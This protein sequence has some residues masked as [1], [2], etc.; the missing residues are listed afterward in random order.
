MNPTHFRPFGLLKKLIPLLLASVAIGNAA[1]TTSG[2]MKRLDLTL[3][4]DRSVAKVMV[5]DGVAT[6]I[7][8]KFNHEGGW[9]RFASREGKPGLMRFKLPAPADK[10]R[11]RAIGRFAKPSVAHDKFPANFYAGKNQ[12]GPIKSDSGKAGSLGRVA[13]ADSAPE[14]SGDSPVEADIW[15]VDG[16][17]VYFF[18]QL[19]GLQ[20]LN[21]A[22]PSDPR[23]TASLRLPAEGQDLYLLPGSGPERNLVLLTRGWSNGDGEWTRINVVTVA[24]G[25]AEITSTRNVPGYLSDSRMVGNRLI[26]ATTEWNWNPDTSDGEWS[27]RT[28]LGEWLISPGNAPQ[29]DGETLIEGDNPLISAGPDWLAI[30]VHP[31]G[32][33][34]VSNVSVFAVRPQGLVKMSPQIR[35]EGSVESKFAMQWADNVLTVV[36]ERNDR[37]NGWS[38]TTILE[39]FQV[40]APGSPNKTTRDRIG[41]LELAEGESLFAT[42]FA[43]NK[44]YIVTFLQ[45]DPLF[46]VDLSDPA[47]PV[48]AGQIE[49][50]GWSSHLEPIGDLLFAIG[51]EENTVV[52]SLFDVANPAD[53]Q[54]LRRLKLGDSGTYS[55]AMWDEK[56]LKVLPQAGLAL[57]PLTR[58]GARNGTARSVV[59]LIDIDTTA[60]DIRLRGSIR[61][62]FDARRADLLG[63]AVV[64]ISQRVMVAADVTDRDVPSILSEVSLAWPV[65]RVFKVGVY[66]L[67]IEDGSSYGGGRATVRVSPANATEQ[68]LAE[69]DLGKGTVRAA[70]YR[71]GKLFILRENS[72]SWT[73]YYLVSDNEDTPS[74]TIVLDVYDASSIPD[75]AL[76]GSRT[77]NVAGGGHMA[78]DRLLWPSPNRPAVVLESG[79]FYGWFRD[80]IIQTDQA[81]TFA[82]AAA[83]MSAKSKIAVNFL[84]YWLPETPPRLVV[85]ETTDPQNPAVESPVA[86]GPKGS[87]FSGVADAAHGLIVLGNT[88]WSGNADD[89]WLARGVALQAARVIEV[90]SSGSPIVRPLIDLP[91]ELFAITELDQDGFLAFTRDTDDGD[92][93]VFGINAC[94][95]YDAFS[96]ASVDGPS[97]AA[98]TAGGRRLFIAG[99]GQVLCYRLTADGTISAESPLETG[100]NPYFLRWVDGTLL[101]SNWNS[102]FTAKENS[103]DVTKWKFST[104]TPSLEHAVPLPNGD[105]LVPFGEYGAERLQP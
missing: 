12:F 65:D 43:G 57:V 16:N 98:A 37:K 87:T 56:A 66:L 81:T 67:Q 104:W 29:A 75:L 26:L 84:P 58:Y 95:G 102:F 22:D 15:K 97:Y 13:L 40:W 38:P 61:H 35:T 4:G 36:S 74:N 24:G 42:R 20:V 85:F 105:L 11:W 49:V 5:P 32:K 70:D 21:L 1:P 59:Q 86:L 18:N 76:L 47:N 41:S 63:G 72:P 71:D 79:G 23:I 55:E 60:R 17:N 50:P 10:A 100:W 14:V 99:E 52:A 19:R 64:S 48:I 27:A 44:A 80:P 93:T 33:W 69:F 92:S 83:P 46:V 78:I 77:I 62:D 25:N 96:I 6:V 73:P 88:Q 51:W 31:A 39:N 68:I 82:E 53:P 54:L 34:D 94:D 3:T 7:L 8:Q 89:N 90:G 101:G 91:G 28:R 45:T 103:T 2:G 9:T 30:A